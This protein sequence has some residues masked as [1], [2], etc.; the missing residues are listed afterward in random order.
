MILLHLLGALAKSTGG[1]GLRSA[2]KVV[3]D[4]LIEGAGHNRPVADRP[5]GWLAT[6]VTL[7][8]SLDRD[9]RR[10]Y[11]Q[12]RQAV[13]R[14]IGQVKDDELKQNVAKTI[15]ILQILN[16][17]PANAQNVA[18]LM[19]PAVDAG[20]MTERVKIAIEELLKDQFVPLMEKDGNLRFFSEKLND[21]EQERGQLNVRTPDFRRIFNNA[22]REVFDPLPTVKVHDS[23]SIT[24][25]VRHLTGGQAVGLAGERETIQTVVA[26]SEA[27]DYDAQRTHLL[28]ESRERAN[29]TAIYLLGRAAPNA[30]ELVTDIY[31]C[32]RIAELHRNDAD[33][34]VRE[35]CT[36]QT[37][38][39]AKL[40]GDLRKALGAS[41]SQGSFLFR[42]RATAVDSLDPDLSKAARSHLAEAAAQVFDRYPEA[43]VRVETVLAEKFLRQPN[44]RSITSQLDPLGLVELGTSPKIR[45]SHK[46]LGSIR[47]YIERNGAV[48]GK[49]LLETF[50][51]H[52]FGWSQDT[53]RYM[54]AALLLAAEIKLK[55]AGRE[56]TVNGQQAVDALKTN[57]SFRSVGVSLRHDRPSMD[58][59]AK[60]AERLTELCGEQVLPLE[61][62]ISKAARQKLPDLQNRLSPL[63]ERLTTLSL[64]GA[65][66]MDTINQQIAAMLQT[67]A[68]DAPVRFGA[69]ESPLF[70][71]LKW[72]IAVKNAFDQGLADTV[73]A[74]RA[75]EGAVAD[76][77][78]TG[79]SGELRTA[80]QDDLSL[81]GQQLAQRD[82]Q[83]HKVDLATK[84]TT[85]EARIADAV[86][87]ML[88]A[89]KE[90]LRGAELD[91]RLLPEWAE[92]TQDEQSGLLNQLQSMEI[93][94]NEDLAGLKR[95]IA[96][97][98]DIEATIVDMKNTIVRDGR[99][100]QRER[101]KPA[102]GG[103]EVWE[104][105]GKQMRV[106]ALPRHIAT[107]DQLNALIEQLERLRVEMAFAE[108]DV[109]LTD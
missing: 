103:N 87:A 24:S 97:Q 37:E 93:A 95:L 56:V 53:L 50:S 64:P 81:I 75:I 77:P 106:L 68:S 4:I 38:R 15:A 66:T 46:G 55:V 86:R 84:L 34:E 11:P 82:F 76:L 8:D 16:N 85:V 39:A 42:G 22:L 104:S 25:G 49:Q 26:F 1:I 30:S 90:R 91:L 2:I 17:L 62:E 47:D 51:D 9:I 7:F 54:V 80:V 19:H 78:G 102:T 101:A 14:T 31:R 5:V 48:E 45:T 21:I 59:L 100:R 20:A 28:D 67:D 98:V 89:Q 35:Y 27:L 72:A 52:P 96:Q 70:D 61:D 109:T 60:A 23:L 43:P 12:I 44:L 73:R 92:F 10:A 13:D 74:L 69:V 29:S 99:G 41:L 6:T 36:S 108:F 33:Q 79:P 40:M 83:R 71:G 63:S 57:T 88:I 107:P 18:S 58:V 32:E 94:V 105:K 65:D 3:Q